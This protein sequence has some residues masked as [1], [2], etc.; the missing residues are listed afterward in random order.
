MLRPT[1]QEF[2]LSSM[3]RSSSSKQP[4]A[5]STMF[6]RGQSIYLHSAATFTVQTLICRQLSWADWR[7]FSLESVSK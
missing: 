4:R 3:P 2:L 7:H 6:D 1:L 5:I